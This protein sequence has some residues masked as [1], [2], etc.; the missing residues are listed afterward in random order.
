ML[1]VKEYITNNEKKLS[2]F[3]K[4]RI[5]KQSN[6]TKKFFQDTKRLTQFTN[7][8]IDFSSNVSGPNKHYHWR[9]K[10]MFTTSINNSRNNELTNNNK[11]HKINGTRCKKQKQFELNKSMY[12][13]FNLANNNQTKTLNQNEGEAFCRN[14]TCVKKKRGYSMNDKRKVAKLNIISRKSSNESINIKGPQLYYYKKP[15]SL[16][17]VRTINS[18]KVNN[19]RHKYKINLKLHSKLSTDSIETIDNHKQNT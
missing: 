4:I 18:E 3:K 14:K 5:A 2:S 9:R 7:D 15:N 1:I 13:M 12:D 16:L 11:L 19:S 8:L 17:N 10:S 6:L